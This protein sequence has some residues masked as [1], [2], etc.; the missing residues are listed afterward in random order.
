MQGEAFAKLVE[1]IRTNTLRQP[2]V[3]APDGITIVDGLNRWRA[4]LVAGVEP[5]FETLDTSYDAWGIIQYILD[6]NLNRRDLSDDQRAFLAVEVIGPALKY[7]AKQRQRAHGGTAPGRPSTLVLNSSQVNGTRASTSREQTAQQAGISPDRVAKAQRIVENAPELKA[8]VLADEISIHAADKVARHRA[9]TQ[10]DDQ[11][12][13]PTN[14]LIRISRLSSPLAGWWWEPL[15]AGL[16]ASPVFHRERLIAPATTW[17]INSTYSDPRMGRVAVCPNVDLYDPAVSDEAIGRIHAACTETATWEYL[18]RSKFPERMA[19]RK[20]LP[21]TA[22]IGVAVE[23]QED[24]AP[25]QEALRKIRNVRVK[26]LLVS[27]REE[28]TFS[29]LSMVQWLVISAPAEAFEADEVFTPSFNWLA[30]LYLQAKDAGCAMFFSPNL[31]D[32]LE[33][34]QEEP[35]S[36]SLMANK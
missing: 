10:D 5:R 4:C 11:A 2:I 29:D 27:P 1:S 24:V 7:A 6:A 23:T 17:H 25:A 19:A 31:L 18:L 26:W 28:F 9:A 20:D 12:P 30:S 21:R 22:W 8:K 34:P 35:R 3:L 36:K 16:D 33:L 14:K 32:R 13:V 15:T